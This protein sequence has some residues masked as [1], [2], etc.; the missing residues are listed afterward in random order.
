MKDLTDKVN[1]VPAPTG[2]LD[3]S[4]WN[5]R[6]NELENAVTDSGQALS[7]PTTNQ[8]TRAIGNQGKRTSLASG[9]L[10][11]GQTAIV[12]NS[13]GGVTLNLPPTPA[14]NTLVHF[15]PTPDGTLYSVNNLTIGRNSQTIMGLSEDMTV[16]GSVTFDNKKITLRF[17]GSTWRIILVSSMGTTL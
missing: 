13:G 11:P 12:N 15:E 2:S 1:N 7:T 6:S 8:L 9:T 16:G 10:E 5:D 14:T 17:D 3:A 4:D